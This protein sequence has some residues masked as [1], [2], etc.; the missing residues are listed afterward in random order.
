MAMLI[1]KATSTN[2]D[3]HVLT[4]ALPS[5]TVSMLSSSNA[6]LQLRS[7]CTQEAKEGPREIAATVFTHGRGALNMG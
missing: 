2:T 7:G 1:S 3:G 6:L 5:L 4:A